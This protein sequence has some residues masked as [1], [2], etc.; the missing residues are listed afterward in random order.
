MQGL[1]SFIDNIVEEESQCSSDEEYETFENVQSATTKRSHKR[2]CLTYNGK[3]N[4]I[5]SVLDESSYNPF[6]APA[7]TVKRIGELH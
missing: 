3:V 1:F 6:I 2:K 7:E 4:S 5:E